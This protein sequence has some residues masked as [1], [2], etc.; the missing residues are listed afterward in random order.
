MSQKEM[1][2][3]MKDVEKSSA[4]IRAEYEIE[5]PRKRDEVNLS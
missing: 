5:H 2:E 1:D 3:P 4:Y